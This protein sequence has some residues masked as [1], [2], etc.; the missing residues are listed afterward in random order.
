[1]NILLVNDDGIDAKGLKVLANKI[2]EK[3]NVFI[4]APISN[5]SAVSNCIT[6]NER[7]DIIQKDKQVWACSGYPADCTSLGLISDLFQEKIDLVISGINEGNNIGTDVVYSGTCAGARQAVIYG[8]PGIAV[9][10]DP[11]DW[12]YAIKNGFKYDAIADF[13]SKNIDKLMSLCDVEKRLFVNINGASIDKYKGAKITK[14]LCVRKYGDTLKITKENNKIFS[15]YIFGSN[16]I[17]Y[18]E[19]TDFS[20]VREGFISI[21]QVNAEP[22]CSESNEYIDGISFSL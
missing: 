17:N 16:K 6:I 12:D 14:N 13:V 4:I 7:L 8:V 21:S 15:S 19:N 9:S 11:I 2:S 1:M 5:R 3:H 10:V 22:C 18:P 20:I